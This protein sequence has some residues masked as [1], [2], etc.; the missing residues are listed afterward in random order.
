[1][2]TQLD[3]QGW[4]KKPNDQDRSLTTSPPSRVLEPGLDGVWLA[5]EMRQI[6]EHV[7][8]AHVHVAQRHVE[9]QVVS[10]LG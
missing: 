4:Q 6:V 5:D 3:Q 1:M 9:Q 2:K 10:G 7:G 8:D